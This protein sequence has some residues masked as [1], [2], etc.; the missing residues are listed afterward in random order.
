MK[1]AMHAHSTADAPNTTPASPAVESFGGAGVGAEVVAAGVGE[2]VGTVGVGAVHV[3]VQL[4]PDCVP[5]G[6]GA[7]TPVAASQEYS[8]AAL[9]ELLHSSRL[10]LPLLSTAHLPSAPHAYLAHAY[11]QPVPAYGPLSRL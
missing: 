11:E 9:H 1:K 8:F 4:A 10:C 7:H 3:V 2:G 6:L 5:D